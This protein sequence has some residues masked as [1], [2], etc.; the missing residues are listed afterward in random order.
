MPVRQIAYWHILRALPCY[1]YVIDAPA[2]VPTPGF[3]RERLSGAPGSKDRFGSTAAE[4]L[5]TAALVAAAHADWDK[6]TIDAFQEGQKIHQ[7]VWGKLVSI[8]RSVNL[9]SLPAED[10]PASYTALYALEVMSPQELKAAVQEDLVRSDASS[11]SILDWTKAF[12]LRGTGIEQEIP[13]TLVLREDLSAAQQQ[14]LLDALRKVADQFGAEILEGKGGIRQAEVK[15]D[16]RKARAAEIEEDLMRRLGPVVLDAPDALKQQFQ[17][18]SAADLIS[19]SRERFTGFLQV[20]EGKGDKSVFWTKY[21]RAYCLKYARDFNLTDSRAERYQLK[22]R[23]T[24][25]LERWGVENQVPGFQEAA[26]DVMRTYMR[27]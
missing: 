24:M 18:G 14:D 9:Q 17:V 13:L 23:V 15:S 25:A 11:R 6:D 4:V 12:R 22:K 7:K 5:E 21:G 10:L 26:E 8:A 20:L 2:H 19:G 1:A 3:L 16:Q 27:R